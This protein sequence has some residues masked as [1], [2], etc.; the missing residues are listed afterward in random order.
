MT[1]PTTRVFR[2][3]KGKKRL[4]S[5]PTGIFARLG[6]GGASIRE[7]LVAESRQGFPVTVIDTLTEELDISQQMLL[8]IIA[9]P[10]ATLT[11]RRAQKRLT[12]QESDRVYRVASVYRAA[13]QLFEG[14]ADAARHWL[15]EPA[16]ALGG[17]P[18]LQHLDTEA[19]ADEVQDLIGRLEHGVI[20]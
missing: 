10:T 3:A 5:R 2:P 16:K 14:D 4:T 1:H 20:T 12:P 7:D 11:R 9:L 13:L 19:G 15:I 6:L 18:P 17:H 8:Q